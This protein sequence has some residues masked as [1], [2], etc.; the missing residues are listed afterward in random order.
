MLQPQVTIE[1]SNGKVYVGEIEVTNFKRHGKGVL[2]FMNG[3]RFDGHWIDDNK[4][5]HGQDISQGGKR[6]LE[7]VWKE[8]RISGEASMT[9]E[10]S[11]EY[12]VE[13]KIR[14]IQK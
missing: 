7:G 10:D 12:Q 11:V 1:Y 13:L 9:D 5:G 6:I 2:T 14:E 3:D 8:G 4:H